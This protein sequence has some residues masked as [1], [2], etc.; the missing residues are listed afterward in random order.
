M[1]AQGGSRARHVVWR[2]I[3]P[4]STAQKA[5]KQKASLCTFSHPIPGRSHPH[6]VDKAGN[7]VHHRLVREQRL[8]APHLVIA[9]KTSNLT[10]HRSAFT[11]QRE[12]HRELVLMQWSENT[13]KTSV[14]VTQRR[15]WLMQQGGRTALRI[16][17]SSAFSS[18]APRRATLDECTTIATSFQLNSSCQRCTEGASAL[19][20]AAVSAVSNVEIQPGSPSAWSCLRHLLFPNILSQTY[21]FSGNLSPC[22][23]ASS[24]TPRRTREWSPA[25]WPLPGGR[26]PAQTLQGRR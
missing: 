7:V 22:R 5:E 12:N 17:F 13:W 11:S 9:H 6:L 2:G 24:Q 20:G 25:R 8:Y 3:W 19:D 21:T 18:A 1:Y 4:G 26:R 15:A 14:Q 16:S 10:S 23:A